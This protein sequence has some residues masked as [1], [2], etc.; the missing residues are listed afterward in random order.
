MKY[1]IKKGYFFPSAFNAKQPISQTNKTME[2]DEKVEIISG[3]GV[4]G[5]V[6]ISQV[7]PGKYPQLRDGQKLKLTSQILK[8][9]DSITY[10]G[11]GFMEQF[12]KDSKDKKIKNIKLKI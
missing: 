6:P 12:K 10:H 1:V 7:N 2:S 8:P 3:E 4:N 5:V 11:S 9:I